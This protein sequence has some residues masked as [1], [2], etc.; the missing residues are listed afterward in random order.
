MS[1]LMLASLFS[2]KS[3]NFIFLL[4]LYHFDEAFIFVFIFEWPKQN[5]HPHWF[6]ADSYK[7]FF[8]KGSRLGNVG[9]KDGI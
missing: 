6:V 7:L 9:K 8:L 2:F 4:E 3:I 5:L 1:I